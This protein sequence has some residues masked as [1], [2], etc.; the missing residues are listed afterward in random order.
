MPTVITQDPELMGGAPVFSGTRV[1]ARSLVDYLKARRPIEEF[2][3]DFPSVSREQVLDVLAS[4]I[5]ALLATGAEGQSQAA[6]S[7]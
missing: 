7:P 4:G 2:L 3:D 1:P 5:E 6:P